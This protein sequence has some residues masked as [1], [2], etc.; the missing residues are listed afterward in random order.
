MKLLYRLLC[1]VLV[2]TIASATACAD[3]KSL[4]IG[5]CEKAYTLAAENTAAVGLVVDDVSPRAP[6]LLVLDQSGKVFAYRIDENPDDDAGELPLLSVCQL[7]AEAAQRPPSAPRGLA[8]VMENDHVVLYFL[9]CA[10]SGEQTTSQLWRVRPEGGNSQCVDLSLYPFRIGDR[11]VL[12]L[13]IDNGDLLVCFDASG[14]IDRNLR[15]RRG[16][17]RLRWN[18][19]YDHKLEFVGHLPDAGTAPSHGLACMKL[20]AAR[21]LWGTVG[22]DHVYCA[23]A[24]TGRGLFH[25]DRPRSSN[26]ENSSCRGM[27]FGGNALW[28]AEHVTGRDRVYRVNVTKNLDAANEG[29]RML[30]HLTMTVRTEPEG[31]HEDAGKVYH[32]YSRPYN[33]DQ[34][35]NQ[36]IW[37]ETEHVEDTS[38]AGSATIKHFTY[39]P[40]GDASGR[41]YMSCVEYASAAARAHASRYEID[42]WTRPYRRYVYPHRVDTNRESLRAA[43]Y[44][45]DDPELF[46]LADRETYASFVK[47][48]RAHIKA[49]YGVAADMRHPYWAARNAL[50]YIQD[51]YYYPNRSKRKP[52]AVDYLRGHYDANPGNLKIELSAV[53]YD[54]SQIIA[55]SGTSVMLTG[56]MRYLGIPA[57]WLGTG[58]E[59]PVEKWDT[60]G[61]GLLAPG[62]TA[63]CSN[64]HRYIQVWLGSRYGWVCFDATPSK[65]EFND[66]DPPPPLWPQ[67]LYMN[68]AAAGHLKDKRVVFNV[69]S[70]LFRPLYRDFEYDEELAVDNNC[71]G[72]QRYN[73]QGRFDK[74][75][76]WKLASH[77]IKVTNLCFLTDVTVAEPCDKTKVT[78]KPEGA[79]D[80]TPEASLSITL[81]QID[82]DSGTASDV[83]CLAEDVPY[84]TRTA[85][86]DLSGHRGERYRVILRK[87]GDCET[88]GHSK[89]FDIE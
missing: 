58:T 73:V 43:D 8:L 71:G 80:R 5:E 48:I 62:E 20:D 75:Q 30:R 59:D 44:L 3:G 29:P 33:T 84:D 49:K 60:N 70:A 76:L 85:V 4:R 35:Q 34:M 78:W 63:T 41:Q 21:Y 39:D 47:R 6:R 57:R 31:K 24:R 50:E 11:E 17:I 16:V 81:Q 42:L 69:G 36:G 1:L 22:D 28:I 14:Y 25:F 88:G 87:N 27:S 68:R 72:D 86:V 56:T 77:R 66:Y 38:R 89:T 10:Q 37:P 45:A 32:Y 7:P 64:G 67:W 15:V 26:S 2:V 46:D 51:H 65:P 40:G 53:P 55:C 83:A 13:A 74:P 61:S 82:A 79:W 52:A 18:Q 54:K 19:A 12:D 9:N 23:E